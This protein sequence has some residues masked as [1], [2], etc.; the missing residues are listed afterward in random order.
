MTPGQSIAP[1]GIQTPLPG[2]LGSSDR[3]VRI[4][5]PAR[6]HGVDMH[7]IARIGCGQVDGGAAAATVATELE[8]RACGDER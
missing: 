1:K 8:Q 4:A 6:V 2:I 3:I 5:T 7:Q